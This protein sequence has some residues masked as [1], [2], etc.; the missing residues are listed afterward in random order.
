[1]HRNSD[2]S[3]ASH[4]VLRTAEAAPEFKSRPNVHSSNPALFHDAV[5]RAGSKSD[6]TS[7][8]RISE[9]VSESKSH[10]SIR[11]RNLPHGSRNRMRRTQP[12]DPTSRQPS[13]NLHPHPHSLHHHR[14][15]NRH[16]NHTSKHH[17]TVAQLYICNIIFISGS[18]GNCEVGAY[19]V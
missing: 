2:C 18:Q 7:I 3:P 19:G 8:S 9:A 10:S 13:R 4:L 11:P 14:I 12:T 5:H 15:L 17:P 16:P 1:A 6:C